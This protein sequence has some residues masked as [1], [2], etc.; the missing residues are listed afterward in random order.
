MVEP[1]VAMEQRIQSLLALDSPRAVIGLYYAAA[2][3]LI[4]LALVGSAAALTRRWA[5]PNAP[6]PLIAVRYAYALVPLGFGM[7][8]AHYSFHFVTSYDVIVPVAQA[9][10]Q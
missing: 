8:L 5:E 9:F 1:T 3:V 10:S 2:L 4:P 7:W 6:W